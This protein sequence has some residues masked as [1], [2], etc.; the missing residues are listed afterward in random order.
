M[1]TL[2][3]FPAPLT[4]EAFAPFGD[5]IQTDGAQRIKI[6][7]GTTER[8]HD[9]ARVDLASRGGHPLINIFR[10]QPRPQPIN[11][12]MVERHPLGSQAFIPLRNACW[13]VVV[14][15]PE[16]APDPSKL[17]AFRARGDQGV[18]YHVGVWHHPLLVLEH[19]HDFLVVDR[20]GLGANCDEVWFEGSGAQLAV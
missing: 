18:N 20:G 10:G 8:F 7:E 11:I 13:L 1:E 5:V 17:R 19:N 15:P 12:L 14:A 4:R 16:D 2:Q 3:L 9:L 6:N